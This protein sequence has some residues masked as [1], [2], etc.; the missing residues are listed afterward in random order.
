[1]KTILMVVHQ[2]QFKQGG[3][4]SVML[5]RS[6]IFNELLGYHSN[7]VTFDSDN[8]YIKLEKDFKLSGRLHEKS[9]I[10][11]LYNY[12]SDINTEDYDSILDIPRTEIENV[13]V[14]DQFYKSKKFLR[15]FSFEGDLIRTEYYSADDD[16]EKEE[17]YGNDNSLEKINFYRNNCLFKSLKYINDVEVEERVFTRDGFCFFLKLNKLGKYNQEHLFLFNRQSKKA[18][19]FNSRNKL[20][21]H[22]IE[23]LCVEV[24][25]E[26]NVVICD[27]PGSVNKIIAINPNKALRF[28]TIHTNH[29]LPPYKFGSEIKK[30]ISMTINNA[31]NVDG[32]IVLTNEQK[33][34]IVRQFSSPEKYFVIPNTMKI[35]TEFIKKKTDNK[36]YINIVSRYASTKQLD[37][38]IIAIDKL[39]AKYQINRFLLEVNF[40]GIG[41]QEEKLKECVSKYSLNDVVSINSYV[42]DVEAVFREADI[43][44]MTSTYEGFSMTFLEAMS[45]KTPVISYDINYGPRDAVTDGKDGFLIKLNDINGLAKKIYEV[46]FRDYDELA[47]ISDNAY[48]KIK[49]EFSHEHA[50]KLWKDLLENK[51]DTKK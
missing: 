30:D 35:N 18:I 39:L 1:M 38:I 17:I 21:A 25:R 16:L 4:T 10:V 23:E 11:N 33:D 7:M 43:T 13:L 27:G 40:Y 42:T 49:T 26:D 51:F 8:D 22:F 5:N 45:N 6:Y 15:Y 12:Y 9:K 48:M 37:H 24:K 20:Y 29:Y 41:S 2:M 44:I 31:K 19:G 14:Q 46:L 3:I 34:N 47:Q 50:A 36:R 32:V 28:L